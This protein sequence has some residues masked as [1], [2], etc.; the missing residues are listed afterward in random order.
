MFTIQRILFKPLAEVLYWEKL[1]LQEEL[2]QMQE[3]SKLTILKELS[4]CD[5][6]K[7]MIVTVILQP[8]IQL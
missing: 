1:V 5:G 8:S 7:D 6:F 4:V 2:S 3:I